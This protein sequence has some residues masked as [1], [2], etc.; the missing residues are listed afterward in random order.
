MIQVRNI[1]CTE[2][3]GV[4]GLEHEAANRGGRPERSEGSKRKGTGMTRAVS[5]V[6]MA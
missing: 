1:L 5:P 2:E 3:N 6:R 4:D